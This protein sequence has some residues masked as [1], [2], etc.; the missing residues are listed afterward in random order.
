MQFFLMATTGM[1][2]KMAEMVIRSKILF[3][4]SNPSGRIATRFTKDL[5]MSDFILPAL[6]A[7]VT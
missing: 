7:I 2:N 5:A 3:F 4:D 1:H 6:L